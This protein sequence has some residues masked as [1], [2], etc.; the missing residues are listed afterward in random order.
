MHDIRD[1]EF[2]KLANLLYEYLMLHVWLIAMNFLYVSMEY[3]KYKVN[4]DQSDV[5]VF[6]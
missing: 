3:M 4:N 6:L 2:L 1:S 5:H